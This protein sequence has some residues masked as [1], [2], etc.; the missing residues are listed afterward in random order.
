MGNIST[1]DS[2]RLPYLEQ[3]KR[4]KASKLTMLKNKQKCIIFGLIEDALGNYHP[5]S[6]IV[7]C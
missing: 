7:T 5:V 1:A 4:Y 6:Y 2:M 3:L